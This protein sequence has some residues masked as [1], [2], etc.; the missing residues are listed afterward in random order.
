MN[1]PEALTEAFADAMERAGYGISDQLF[2]ALVGEFGAVLE[3]DQEEG[4]F[5][6]LDTFLDALEYAANRVTHNR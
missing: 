1:T 6:S 2:N 3:V 4:N 5:A